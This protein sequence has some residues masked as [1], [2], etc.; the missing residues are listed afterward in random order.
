MVKIADFNIHAKVSSLIRLAEDPDPMVFN[1][2]KSELV[3]MGDGV[4]STLERSWCDGN[5]D[6]DHRDRIFEIIREI[7]VNDIKTELEKWKDSSTR[8][9]LRGALIIARFQYPHLDYDEV[10]AELE[11]IKQKVWL[12]INDEH[13][14][15]EIVKIFNHVLFEHCGF[16]A[17]EDS[18]HSPQNSLINA[19]LESKKGNQLSLSILYSVVAQKLQIPIFGIDLPNN[20]VLGFMDEF[21]TLKMLGLDKFERNVLFYINPYRKGRIFDQHEIENYLKSHKLPLKNEF[22]IPC[23]NSDILKRLIDNLSNAYQ[24]VNEFKKV[25]ELNQ[26]RQI[27]D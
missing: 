15:F 4:V 3:R 20:F 16:R 17:S 27:L 21:Q 14:A 10:D 9:L 6:E 8:D 7:Q 11:K 26:I 24:K 18:F 22:F 2:V 5:T 1:H 25:K 13:T 23:T 19:V 12:E